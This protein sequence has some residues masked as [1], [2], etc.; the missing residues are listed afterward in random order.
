MNAL[1]DDTEP[2]S[3]PYAR[4]SVLAVALTLLTCGVA[5]LSG[6]CDSNAVPTERPIWV[7][8]GVWVAN[9]LV[10]LAA[11]EPA[12]RLDKSAKSLAVI[13]TPALVMRAILL[14]T[15][16]ILEID[17][18]RYLWDGN[19]LEAGFS[20]YRYSP[21]EIRFAR[22]FGTVDSDL[23]HLA[24]KAGSS[25]A[26]AE[27]IDTVHFGELRTP[28]PPVSQAVFATAAFVT[29]DDGP[30][31]LH[32]FV[33]KLLITGFDLGTMAVL[34]WLLIRLGHSP[35][36]AIVYG[37]CPLPL[38]E[39]ANSGHLD[40]I[41]VFFTLAAVAAL[42]INATNGS[43]V[44]TR[45]A[46]LVSSVLLA[47]A[48]G[49]KLF[50]VVLVP[51]FAVWTW[52]TA[53][54]R[55]LVAA[56]LL[57]GTLTALTLRPLLPD[58]SMTPEQTESI[59][60]APPGQDDDDDGL[61]AFLHRWEINDLLFAVIVENLKQSEHRKTH[62]EPWFSILPDGTRESLL[63]QSRNVV[64][65]G[66][67]QPFLLA[68]AS[69]L[70]VYLLIIAWLTY[71]IGRAPNDNAAG[72]RRWLESVFLALAWLW[73]LAPTQNP[74]YWTWALPF[75]PFA[76]SRAWL[77]LGILPLLYY[78][79]FWFEAHTPSVTIAGEAYKGVDIFDF[80]VVWLEFAPFW[81]ALALGRFRE[82][83]P[84]RGASISD[85]ASSQATSP[86]SQLGD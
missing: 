26:L 77:L 60:L 12:A 17:L 23:E 29:P 56:T 43:K 79:R 75:V 49:A 81:L 76:R 66:S 59:S 15:T 4:L 57:C 3:S 22:D 35:G 39:F 13:F 24:A 71:R 38:K 19:A 7:L 70:V 5:A 67:N 64:D 51:L 74:W 37:W 8:S 20:P 83:R 54:T 31:W 84:L 42:T 33:I 41:A 36:L 18:Y 72:S 63:E 28:Y 32:L 16:P 30:T 86:T 85:L 27:I 47:L 45:A 78:A 44:S 82:S 9:G 53:G 58:S 73:L 48:I 34:A 80:L 61:Q 69:V 55:F 46:T 6:P 1:H 40:A 11:I 65:H 25:P 52:R 10:Y 62:P 2:A 21:Q 14:P 68:R 50:P